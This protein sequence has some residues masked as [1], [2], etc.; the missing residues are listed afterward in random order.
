MMRKY[1]LVVIL[2]SEIK[3]EEQEETVS[4]IKKI[5]ANVKGELISTNDWG[6]KEFAYP[7]NKKTSGVY[8]LFE[9]KAEPQTVLLIKQ[10]FQLEEKIVRYL[11]TV[12]EEK[13][14]GGKNELKV[15]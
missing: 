12:I 8:F 11:L 15:A 9:Y 7:I 6:K 2:D 1:E 13:A 5:I 3:A 14:K 4:R 10:K